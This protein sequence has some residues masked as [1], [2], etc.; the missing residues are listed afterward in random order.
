MGSLFDWSTTAGSNTTV[1]GINVNTG[2]SPGNVDN[3]FRSIMALIRNSFSATLQNFLAGVSALPI[4]S[5][6][7]GSSTAADARTALGLGSAATES[8]VPVAKG[9]TGAT[10]AAAAFANI[11]VAASSLS[12][13]GY[14]KLQNGLI[15]QWGS[16]STVAGEGAQNISFPIAFPTQ[17]FTAVATLKG[18]SSAGND[19][20]LQVTGFNTTTLNTFYQAASSGN[21]GYGA[22]WIAVGN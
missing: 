13:N 5:G 15:L 22:Y 16:V 20:W 2:M 9:G 6:G 7:T 21:S 4:S 3:A 10:T 17:C 11:A 19:M 8:T 1:D 12:G 18:N 14:I